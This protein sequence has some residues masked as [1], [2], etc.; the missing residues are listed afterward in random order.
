MG[1]LYLTSIR[2]FYWYFGQYDGYIHKPELKEAAMSQEYFEYLAGL[3]PN[4]QLP[5]RNYSRLF[6]YLNDKKFNKY[7]IDRDRNRAQDGIYLRYLFNGDLSDYPDE[8]CSV[9]ELLIG[10][11]QKTES[12]LYDWEAGDQTP[13]WFWMMLNNLGLADMDNSVFNPF[14]VDQKIERMMNRDYEPN[15]ENGALFVVN[16]PYEDFRNLEI[17][18]QM[19]A[20]VC[21][22]FGYQ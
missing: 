14:D 12:R 11:A 16:N 5:E 19:N 1:K 8:D 13:T 21:E 3:V 20:F 2:R 15:G 9:L 18:S 4:R 22:V 10:V 7:L 6:L 17:C